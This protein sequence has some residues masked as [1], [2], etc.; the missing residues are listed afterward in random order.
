MSKM[1]RVFTWAWVEYAGSTEGTERPVDAL[2]GELGDRYTT[3][4]ELYNRP[5]TAPLLKDA[6]L[7]FYIDLDL[8]WLYADTTGAPVRKYLSETARAWRLTIPKEEVA[9]RGERRH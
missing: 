1:Q 2:L 8:A 9:D 5:D 3:I 6:P 4:S 7:D